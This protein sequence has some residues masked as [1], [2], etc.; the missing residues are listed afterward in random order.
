MKDTVLLPEIY[1]ILSLAFVAN[2]LPKQW[3]FF[4]FLLNKNVCSMSGAES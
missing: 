3:R 4:Y 1:T 2:Y